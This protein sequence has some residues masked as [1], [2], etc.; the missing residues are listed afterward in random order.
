MDNQRF[1]AVVIFEDQRERSGHEC[2]AQTDDITDDH[3]AALFKI[4]L[5]RL[6]NE[7][8]LRDRAK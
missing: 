7:D 6:D 2:L 3:A 5:P 8:E 4:G 1:H